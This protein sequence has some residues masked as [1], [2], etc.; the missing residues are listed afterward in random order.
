[1]EESG[2]FSWS[3]ERTHAELSSFISH[4]LAALE[5]VSIDD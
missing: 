1:M 3:R 5:S 2:L 4:R